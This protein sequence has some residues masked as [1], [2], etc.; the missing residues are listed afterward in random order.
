VRG[1]A[2]LANAAALMQ[3]ALELDEGFY[4][5][6]PHLFFG[7]YYGGRSPLLGGDFARADRHFARASEL[8]SGKLLMVDVLQAQYLDRQ[9][10]DRNAFHA[11]LLHV[12][13]APADLDPELRLV[14]GI[15]KAHAARLLE[16]E[17][18]WF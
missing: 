9:R 18:D 13:D 1:V 10:L 11:H 16:H 12:L 4:H 7:V 3:R 8:N 2:S 6:G 17:T 14:N 5:A 15:A